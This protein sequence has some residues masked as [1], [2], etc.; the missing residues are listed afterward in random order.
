MIHQ[1]QRFK[2]YFSSKEIENTTLI[3]HDYELTKRS[4]FFLKNKR[5]KKIWFKRN[6]IN[7][8]VYCDEKKDEY[9]FFL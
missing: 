7:I 1:Y 8:H 3:F 9:N 6:K 5:D 2:N 4:N